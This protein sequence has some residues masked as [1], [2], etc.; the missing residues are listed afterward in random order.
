MST[1]WANVDM[2]LKSTLVATKQR[3]VH[4]NLGHKNF[5]QLNHLLQEIIR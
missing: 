3:T 5:T 1:V 2:G 4:F